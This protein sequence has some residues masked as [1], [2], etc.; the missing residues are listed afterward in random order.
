MLI[1]TPPH[2]H[3]Y[4]TSYSFLF[5]R[6]LILSPS[7]AHLTPPP[8]HPYSTSYSFLFHRLLILSPSPAHLTPPP[9]HPYSPSCSFLFHLL[10]ILNPPPDH[11]YSIS[12]SSYSTSFAF[13]LP[14][15]LIPIPPPAHPYSTSC[16]TLFHLLLILTSPSVHFTEDY[17]CLE[18]ISTLSP[19]QPDAIFCPSFT[20]YSFLLTLL[21]HFS[22]P[23]THS[24][25]IFHLYTWSISC[26]SLFSLGLDTFFLH[27]L[28]V[29]FFFSSVLHLFT[30]PL[31]QLLFLMLL[32]VIFV[33]SKQGSWAQPVICL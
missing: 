28:F 14:L 21:P 22:L 8:S 6:L 30:T 27:L 33:P 10:L 32:L 18:H 11:P 12:C 16:S 13:L 5:R 29:L 7:P 3:P 31:L 26:A 2:S 20:V 19:P 4:S 9:S 24:S 1:L 17:L 23:A 25:S 15:L